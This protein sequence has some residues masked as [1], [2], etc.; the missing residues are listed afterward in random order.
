MIQLDLCIPIFGDSSLRW[1][2]K[3]VFLL[4]HRTFCGEAPSFCYS[5]GSGLRR[6]WRIL[7]KPK[8]L[9]SCYVW[10]FEDANMIRRVPV[11]S[12]LLCL[13]ETHLGSSIPYE[14]CSDSDAAPLLQSPLAALKRKQAAFFPEESEEVYQRTE[15]NVSVA[16]S[17]FAHAYFQACS[18]STFVSALE[19]N[20]SVHVQAASSCDGIQ[21]QKETSTKIIPT[22]CCSTASTWCGGCEEQDGTKEAC[23]SC[24]GGYVLEDGHCVRCAISSSLTLIGIQGQAARIC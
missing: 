12:L 11:F 18:K 3:A 23:K 6:T 24:Q 4:L 19:Q 22:D 15:D 8:A 2:T 5:F 10:S 13:R 1:L 14:N 16:P 9:I 20:D 7:G 21:L 17:D